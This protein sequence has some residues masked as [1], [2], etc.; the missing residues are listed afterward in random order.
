MDL[1]VSKY[2]FF[3]EIAE[4]GSIT[5]AAEKLH[6]SQPALSKYLHRLEQSLGTLLFD[7]SVLPIRLTKAGEVFLRYAVQAVNQEKMCNDQIT[8]LRDN[9]YETLRVGIG[10]WRASCT[11]PALLPYFE[12]KYPYVRVMI[13]EG[14]SDDLAEQLQRGNI[15]VSILGSADSYP[16][17]TSVPLRNEHV[18]MLVNNTN[19]VLSR[20]SIDRV[21]NGGIPHADL[22]DFRQERFILTSRRQGFA[23]V[24]YDYFSRIH[25]MP[26]EILEITNLQTGMYMTAQSDY[27]SF[28]PEIAIHSLLIPETI[29]YFTFGDPPLIYP[30]SIGYSDAFPMK[31][32]T[33]AFIETT[34]AFTNATFSMGT[35]PIKV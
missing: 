2:G 33:M 27:I 28:V 30:I 23:Q 35:A 18:L 7:R 4:Q 31:K 5:K 12:E 9:D 11:L 6:I 19:P 26:R 10:T 29:S 22:P 17:I 32:S 20:L 24:I 15:D 1:F 34:I 13:Y 21:K 3:I 16:Y 25:F 14:L 8:A